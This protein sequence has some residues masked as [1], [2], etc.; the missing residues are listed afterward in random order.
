[1][2]IV[3][4]FFFN[5]NKKC[6]KC[7]GGHHY[8]LCLRNRNSEN[9]KLNT[10]EGSTH[11]KGENSNS[12]S[13]TALSVRRSSNVILQTIQVSIRGHNGIAN[14]NMLLDTG[15]DRSYISSEFVERIGP[16][17]SRVENIAYCAFGSTKSSEERMRYIFN[18]EALSDKFSYVFEATEV[19]DL[20][21]PIFR[22]SIP[23]DLLKLFG[24][25][26]QID[27]KYL[28]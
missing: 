3:I 19:E 4:V 7:Q 24:N 25:I 10:F 13:T 28:P 14:A 1:M 16:E 23:S 12:V 2:L 9:S 27:E 15:S 17:F 6:S 8:L 26:Q 5:C 18:F 11:D 21:G 20:C 22:K